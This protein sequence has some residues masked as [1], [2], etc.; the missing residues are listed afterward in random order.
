MRN[1]N[2]RIVKTGRRVA[3][4]AIL[5]AVVV[6]ARDDRSG[7]QQ[8]PDVKPAFDRVE[9]GLSNGDAD[10][11]APLLGSQTY[12]SLFDG[13]QGYY[14]SGQAFYLLQDFFRV[15][16]PVSFKYVNTHNGDAPYATGEYQYETRGRRNVARVYAA[17]KRDGS[18][19]KLSQLSIR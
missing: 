6:V 12:L 10:R 7:A 1:T 16:R 11:L 19:W 5:A 8:G 9:E 4:L 13:S 17:F 15:N 14:S 18:S 2:N 3:L